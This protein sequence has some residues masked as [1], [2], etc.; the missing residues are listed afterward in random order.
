MNRKDL[1]QSYDPLAARMI[2]SYLLKNKIIEKIHSN[3]K[4][5]ISIDV[6]LNSEI[7][8]P[9]DVNKIDYKTMEQNFEKF[10]NHFK[11]NPQEAIAKVFTYNN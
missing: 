5:N 7:V 2:N 4:V 11:K 8:K 9:K 6:I 10:T 1:K 3:E